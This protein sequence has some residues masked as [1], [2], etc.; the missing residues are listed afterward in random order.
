M[1]TAARTSLGVGPLTLLLALCCLAG[2]NLQKLAA[3]NFAPIL[4]DTN[5]EF[6]KGTIL[7]AAREAAPGLL[8]TLDGVV[9]A[10]PENPELLVLQAEL[11]A[12]FA[13]GFLEEEQRRIAREQGDEAEAA[14]ELKAWA[15]ALYDKSRA[16]ARRVIE[17]EHEGLATFIETAPLDQLRARLNEDCDADALPGIFWL[18]FAWGARMNLKRDEGAEA[19]KDVP[20]VKVLMEWAVSVNEG[21]F[22]GGPHL[23][24]AMFELALGRSIG[25]RPEQG[26][27]HIE[28]VERI[29]GRRALMARVFYCEFY[30]PQI[31]TPPGEAS[32]EEREKQARKVWDDYITTLSAVMNA[33]PKL[34]PEQSLTNAIAKARAADL[35]YRADDILFPPPGVKVPK[36]PGD[37]DE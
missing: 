20:R 6:Q 12:S 4:R 22:N 37:E 13:F 27:K 8:A 10:S 16:A 24:L 26:L 30:L 29:T 9:L 36:R 35:Y 5:A 21:Y 19:V 15:S 7:R 1:R 28:A 25:G 14:I 18:G 3:D 34:W 31:Q 2:C 23:A 32:A 33:D 11:C 17:L